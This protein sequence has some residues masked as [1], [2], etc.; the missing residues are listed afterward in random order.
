MMSGRGRYGGRGNWNRGGGRGRGYENPRYPDKR[1]YSQEN[2]YG[3]TDKT[4]K[5]PERFMLTG[6]PSAADVYN[7]L[8]QQEN[9]AGENL[10]TTGVSWIVNPENPGNIPFL[11]PPIRPRRADYRRPIRQAEEAQEGEEQ[12]EVEYET[13]VEEY[14]GDIYMWKKGIDDYHNRSRKIED[15]SKMLFY[16]MKSYI[17][18]DLRREI[19]SKKGP[20]V[21]DNECPRELTEDIKEVLL[22]QNDGATGNRLDVEMQK[23]RFANIRQRQ[24]QSISD[25]FNQFKEELAALKVIQQSTGRCTDDQWDIEWDEDAKVVSFISKLDEDKGGDWLK[26]FRYRYKQLPDTLDQAYTEAATAEREY[27]G[28]Y[29]RRNMERINAYAM[30]QRNGSGRGRNGGGGRGFG[31]QRSYAQVA[32]VDNS[33][34]KLDA[35][36][37]L[38]CLDHQKGHCRHGEYCYYSHKPSVTTV[39]QHRASTQGATNQQQDQQIVQAV[40]QV[41]FANQ[42][43]NQNSNLGGGASGSKQQGTVAASPAKR[44]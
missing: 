10:G 21:W 35:H 25:F 31:Q 5:K 7:W 17:G 29:Q 14:D 2:N 44:G 33:N 32:Q 26:G 18:Q 3:K 24:G 20:A 19:S 38:C 39:G 42:P 37:K 22:A 8:R 40:K 1:N 43:G 9:W 16:S 4:D 15:D 30:N 27:K 41:G 34:L 23:R 11:E 13:D 36:G 6:K 28:T 12:E